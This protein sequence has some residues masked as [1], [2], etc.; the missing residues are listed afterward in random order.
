MTTILS[1]LTGFLSEPMNLIKA[2][3]AATKEISL[4]NMATT[5][6]ASTRPRKRDS[7]PTIPQLPPT[8]IPVLTIVL[9]LNGRN[10]RI[11]TVDC[12]CRP[13][14]ERAWNGNP[15]LNYGKPSHSKPPQSVQGVGQGRPLRSQ[16][17][18]KP[19]RGLGSD[20]EPATGLYSAAGYRVTCCNTNLSLEVPL[21]QAD[22]HLRLPVI[23]LT[24]PE[25]LEFT[26]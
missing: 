4:L 3:D 18:S 24:I 6:I 14:R 26:A 12:A 17:H 22:H 19:T 5:W 20:G 15:L 16:S 8:S 13:A 23:I 7:N 25:T 2:I 1:M 9:K 21:T 11:E 10:S